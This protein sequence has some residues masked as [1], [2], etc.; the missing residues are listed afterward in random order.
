[1]AGNYKQQD[2]HFL[3][4]VRVIRELKSSGAQVNATHMAKELSVNY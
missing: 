3:E 2:E 4:G 1:M